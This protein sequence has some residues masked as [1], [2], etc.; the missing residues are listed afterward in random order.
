M[1]KRIQELM[2]EA[3][4]DIMVVDQ[5]EDRHFEKFADLIIDDIIGVI[6]SNLNDEKE[7]TE[8]TISGFKRDL[9]K[10]KERFGRK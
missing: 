10:I 4:S 1:N 7:C 6:E 3:F 9:E 5:L 8:F 2:N